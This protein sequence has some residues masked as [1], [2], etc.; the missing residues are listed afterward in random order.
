MF[1]IKFELKLNSS[2][3]L[4]F[5]IHGP[6]ADSTFVLSTNNKLDREYQ[7]N[8]IL[9]LI[10]TDNGQPSLSSYY[11]LIINLLDNNDNSPIFDKQIYYVDLQENNL[12]NTTL[13]QVHATDLDIN[14]NSLITYEVN[15]NEIFIDNQTGIIRTNIQ[16]DYEKIQNFTFNVTAKD[17]PIKDKQLQTIAM[18]Y[19]KI[20]NQNDNIPKVINKK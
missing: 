12:I 4:P 1:I 3:F 17:H 15:S 5:D 14:N 7:D 8:Y 11:K 18:V 20:I 10:L 9:N 16:F 19:V 2:K 6:F 13:I